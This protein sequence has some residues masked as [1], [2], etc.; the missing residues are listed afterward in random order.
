VLF[1]CFV[2]WFWLGCWYQCKW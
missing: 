1:V 2:S